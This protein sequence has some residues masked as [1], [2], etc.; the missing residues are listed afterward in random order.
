VRALAATR[1][2]RTF[3]YMKSSATN[4]TARMMYRTAFR[5][6]GLWLDCQIVPGAT[7]LSTRPG[8][9]TDEG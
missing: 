6:F 4:T 5:S 8:S 7:W 9:S 2:L 1:R 3:T